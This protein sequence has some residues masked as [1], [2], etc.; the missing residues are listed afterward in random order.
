MRLILSVGVFGGLVGMCGEASAQHPGRPPG[1]HSTRGPRPDPAGN[2]Y[3]TPVQ[4][5]YLGAAPVATV[6]PAAYPVVGTRAFGYP[7][8]GYPAY[9]PKADASRPA[10]PR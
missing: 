2:L 7:G 9:T 3:L 5:F 1:S 8:L 10:P 6:R 4:N